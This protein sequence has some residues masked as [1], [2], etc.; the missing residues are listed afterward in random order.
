MHHLTSILKIDN[1]N[2]QLMRG[3]S[4]ECFAAFMYYYLHSPFGQRIST[5][6]VALI[7]L[8]TPL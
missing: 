2:M 7:Y 4:Y 8:F 5:P 1:N 6:T 3:G